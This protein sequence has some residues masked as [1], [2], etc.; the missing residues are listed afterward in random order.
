MLF[1]R[2]FGDKFNVWDENTFVVNSDEKEVLSNVRF[3]GDAEK[4]V[5][6]R[7]NNRM[8]FIE[9]EYSQ[10]PKGELHKMIET[11]GYGEI[12]LSVRN[13]KVIMIK[14]VKQEKLSNE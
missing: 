12:T 14:S 7:K 9:K 2:Y 6:K 1:R 10:M 5:I 4:I 13:N 8:T 11:I 3:C